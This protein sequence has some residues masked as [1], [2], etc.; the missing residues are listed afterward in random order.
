MAIHELEILRQRP[1]A[2]GK[3]LADAGQYT[4][5]DAIAHYRVDPHDPANAAIVDLEKAVRGADGLGLDGIRSER[6]RLVEGVR[7]ITR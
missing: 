7:S 6:L 5:I 4:R 3:S 2:D 1:Y